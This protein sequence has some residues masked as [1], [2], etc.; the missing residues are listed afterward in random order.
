M[1]DRSTWPAFIVGCHRSGT[2]LL[3]YLLDAHPALACPPESKFLAAFGDVLTYPQAM[4]GL[5][6]LGVGPDRL[7]ADLRRMINAFFQEYA[8]RH[9]KRRWIDKTPNYARLLPF[10]DALFGHEVLFLLM[11]RHP[12]DTADSLAHLPAF[13]LDEPED[14]DIAASV[15][16]HGRDRAAW[17]RHWVDTAD[18]LAWFG[19]HTPARTHFVRYEAL[20]TGPARTLEEV[21]EFLGEAR[22]PEV[23]ADLIDGAFTRRHPPGYEDATIRDSHGIHQSS[24]GKWRRWPTAEVDRLWAIAADVAGLLGYTSPSMESEIYGVA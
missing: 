5:R 2:T 12:L 7:L 6:S 22:S 20:V 21:L 17:V 15:E 18:T 24:I 3:R 8:A 23:V 10:L 4:R 16:R 13:N 9:G 19:A 11:V 14:P 1:A